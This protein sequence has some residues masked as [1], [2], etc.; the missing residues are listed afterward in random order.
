MSDGVTSPTDGRSQVVHLD[1]A[2]HGVCHDVCQRVLGRPGGPGHLDDAV[3]D[4]DQPVGVAEIDHQVV[5]VRG[6]DVVGT[7][8]RLHHVAATDD[9][10]KLVGV[11]ELTEVFR[12][13]TDIAERV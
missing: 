1:H 10:R 11:V 13:Q 6:D 8:Q 5:D 4:L 12:V 2:R 3:L 9:A 7:G